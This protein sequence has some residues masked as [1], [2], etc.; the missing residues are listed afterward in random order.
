[1]HN[2]KP[3]GG[4]YIRTFST[5]P[6]LS[7]DDR[8]SNYNSDEATMEAYKKEIED[9]CKNN[10]ANL[11]SVAVGRPVHPDELVRIEDG[12]YIYPP[13]E[14]EADRE[15]AEAERQEYLRTG[16]YLNS[17]E[18]GLRPILLKLD[19]MHP[20]PYLLKLDHQHPLPIL[21]KLDHMHPLPILLKLDHQHPL[22]ML[23]L[24]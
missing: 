3:I 18:G 8:P 9:S 6:F 4:S 19:H 5:T 17:P 13:M 20:H 10:A 1:M 21:L 11:Y 7:V 2:F 16:R 22:L 24:M 23:N 14:E 15:V 12:V